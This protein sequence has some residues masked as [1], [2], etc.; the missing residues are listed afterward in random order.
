MKS[1]K[2]LLSAI[3][4][5]ILTSS[6]IGHLLVGAQNPVIKVGVLLDV[7]VTEGLALQ[8]A[9]N[10]ADW[11]VNGPG[12]G[13]VIGGVRYDLQFI[14]ANE[15]AAEGRPDLAAQEAERLITESGVDFLVGTSLSE[16][17]RAVEE[18]CADYQ[19]I[20]IHPGCVDDDLIDC[21]TGTCGHCVRCDYNRYKYIFRLATNSTIVGLGTFGYLQYLIESKL[22]RIYGSPV[23]TAVLFEDLDWTEVP[24][25]YIVYGGALGPHAEIVYHARTP[26]TCDDFS[27]YLDGIK[28]SGAHLIVVLYYLP[29]S[30]T[31]VR[32]FYEYPGH[33][34]ALM[35]G[36]VVPAQVQEFWDQTL[37]ECQYLITLNSAGGRTPIITEPAPITT[38]EFY[39]KFV[40]LNGYSPA[41]NAYTFFNIIYAM[42]QTLETAGIQP[43]LD[44]AKSSALIPYIEQYEG[45]GILG[46]SKFTGP[47]PMDPSQYPYLSVNPTMK[48]TLHDTFMNEI[49]P[50]WAQ[51]YVRIFV[52]Q[53]IDG[54]RMVISPIDQLYSKKTQIPTWMYELS[55]VDLNF[56]GE[57]NI[58]DIITIG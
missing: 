32:Q 6:F 33:I 15:H 52:L 31:L 53:W 38:I 17:G 58:L 54:K 30:I 47:H 42:K 5:A 45:L 39:D 25:N 4:V 20:F 9:I 29:N 28:A 23:K 40:E 56:D 57:V 18:V 51:G 1:K 22:V 50:T 48:G 49:G 37:G 24:Y 55:D 10:V 21:G 44:A 2:L 43:P 12:G 3:L 19:K 35:A 46:K 14:T 8:G 16:C 13:I 7:A 26:F 34:P 11:W 41:W 36:V 27:S